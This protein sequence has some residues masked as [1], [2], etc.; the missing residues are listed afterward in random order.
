MQIGLIQPLVRGSLI[1]IDV[2]SVLYIL[3]H[4]IL[5]GQAR[6]VRHHASANL[7]CGAVEHSHNYGLAPAPAELSGAAEGAIASLFFLVHVLEFSADES[8]IDFDFAALAADLGETAGA[9]CYANPV[10]HEPCGLLSDPDS[11]GDLI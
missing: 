11:F 10:H 2:G 5:Q 3:E 1:G 7:A 6:N 4:G 9:K 8:F